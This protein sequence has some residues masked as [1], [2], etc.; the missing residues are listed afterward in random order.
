MGRDNN[1]MFMLFI[2]PNNAYCISISRE[3]IFC[4]NR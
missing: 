4:T 3:S 1:S 2:T